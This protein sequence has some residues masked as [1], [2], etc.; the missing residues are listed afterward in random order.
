VVRT[1]GADTVW[2]AMLAHL[3]DNP[4]SGSLSPS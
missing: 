3:I 1:A 4:S 2:A